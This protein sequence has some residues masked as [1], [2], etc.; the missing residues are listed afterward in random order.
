MAGGAETACADHK[1]NNLD[2][3]V[4]NFRAPCEA[5]GCERFSTWGLSGKQPSHCRDHGPFKDGLVLTV[6]TN[7]S[8]SVPRNS[9]YHAVEDPPS[10]VKA[11]CYF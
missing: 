5:A 8:N 3:P 4:I 6:R 2:G 1:S 9:S 11:E 10:Q 7:H